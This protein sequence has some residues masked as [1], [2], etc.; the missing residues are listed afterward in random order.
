MH[1]AVDILLRLGTRQLVHR[2]ILSHERQGV[3]IMSAQIVMVK[4]I[5]NVS[6]HFNL[7]FYISEDRRK[8][9]N[10]NVES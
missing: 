3:K 7:S 6:G 4:N 2:L 5:E 1:S 9:C 8:K 10:E